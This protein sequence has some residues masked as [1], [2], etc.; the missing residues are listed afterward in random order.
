MTLTNEQKI[1]LGFSSALIVVAVALF[2]P[3]W[4]QPGSSETRIW[5]DTQTKVSDQLQSMS[6]RFDRSILSYQSYLTTGDP[7]SLKDFNSS[8]TQ[9]NQDL[10]NLRSV[11][12]DPS[13]RET[14]RRLEN[15]IT[16]TVGQLQSL[17]RE[18]ATKTDMTPQ[19]YA[20]AFQAREDVRD[21][22]HDLDKAQ[23]DKMHSI[24]SRLLQYSTLPN[25]Q[26]SLGIL[27]MTFL[28]L[29]G[30]ATFLM[31][32]ERHATLS[33]L[34]QENKELI[35]KVKKLDEQLDRLAHRDYLTEVLNTKGLEQVLAVEENRAGRAGGQLVALI[36]N[37]D[38]FRRVNEGLGHA[39]GDVVLKEVGRRITGTLRPSDHVGRI[40][41]DEFLVLLPDTQLAY[42]VR[43]ADRLRLAISDSPLRSASELINMTVS[44][45]VAALV[46]K[47]SSIEEVLSLTRTALKRSKAGGKN[48]VSVAREGAGPAVEEDAPVARDIV[49]VLCDGSHFRT[50]FQP[51][52]DLTNETTAGYEIFTRGPDGAFESPAEFFRVCVENNVLTTVDL[53]CLKLC[54]AATEDVKEHARFHINLF[55]STILDT[56]IEKLLALF[57]S[58]KGNRTFCIEISEEQFIGDPGYLREHVNAMKQHGILVAIDDV[59][60]G[61]SSLESLILLEPDIV[62]VDRKYVTGVAHEPAK[63]RL[64]KRLT[65]VGKSLGAEIV[66]EGIETRDDLPVLKELGVRYGQGYLWGELME[67]LPNAKSEKKGLVERRK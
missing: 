14:L 45:G 8:A 50:V 46:A 12:S 43:V 67:V 17:A 62:K 39:V 11:D 38:N 56:P 52:V 13:F 44:V 32:K 47:T 66:A 35:E 2:G 15:K 21:I 19:Q 65:N 64:L 6:N 25:S 4:S 42:A 34:Q 31:S 59:G 37:C 1:V 7:N 24:E 48:K 60:Y 28:G 27:L 20:A 49:E 16:N 54:I 9:I 55:P 5:A 58:D 26:A 51:V 22:Q 3:I 10:F 23:Q 41:G 57:P 40:G 53:L 61:R 18:R 30:L 33:S 36:V 63:A 29:L